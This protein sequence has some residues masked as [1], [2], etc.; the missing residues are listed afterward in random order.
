MKTICSIFRTFC[1]GNRRDVRQ[2]FL[3]SSLIGQIS[4]GHP[5]LFETF[6]FE[7]L[8]RQ[9][10]S[11][12]AC[13]SRIFDAPSNSVSFLNDQKSRRVRKNRYRA[14]RGFVR[15]GQI[16]FVQSVG[17]WRFGLCRLRSNVL[18]L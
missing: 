5:N 7:N 14:A 4:A 13:Y 1:S 6:R 2:S 11:L 10:Q 16:F 17:V 12:L 3:T 9:F 8:H 15:F 18:E